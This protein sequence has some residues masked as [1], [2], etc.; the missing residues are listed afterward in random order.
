[1]FSVGVNSLDL[2]LFG[3]AF[4]NLSGTALIGGLLNLVAAPPAT[5]GFLR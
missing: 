1:M 4:A 2:T 5:P 3:L